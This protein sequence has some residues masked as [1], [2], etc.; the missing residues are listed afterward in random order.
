MNR[1]PLLVSGCSC[2]LL[3]TGCL[4]DTSR[5]FEVP[6]LAL[7]NGMYEN[8]DN[9]SYLLFESGQVT[10][11]TA[12]N[13]VTR[14]YRVDDDL[15]TIEFNSGSSRTDSR[16]VMRIQKQG[17][18]LTCNQCPAIQLSNVWTRVEKPMKGKAN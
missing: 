11:Q 9:G 16:L 6:Q 17:E 18:M 12:D 2:A 10:Y 3:L 8:A 15:I 1:L 5:P 13:S 14:T 4:T 7:F